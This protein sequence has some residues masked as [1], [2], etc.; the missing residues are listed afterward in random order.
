MVRK[1]LDVSG[2]SQTA[3]RH[4]QD[5]GL[6]VSPDFLRVDGI[7]RFAETFRKFSFILLGNAI[8]A[9]TVDMQPS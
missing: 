9:E 4:L 1:L 2:V 7:V 6:E 8:V 3:L 5:F